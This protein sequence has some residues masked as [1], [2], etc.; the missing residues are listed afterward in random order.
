M[1]NIN[2]FSLKKFSQHMI[3]SSIKKREKFMIN[4]VWKVSKEAVVE[5]GEWMTSLVCLLAKDAVEDLNRKYALSLLV[6]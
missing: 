6:K 2:V 1:T 5:E 3:Y 4:T